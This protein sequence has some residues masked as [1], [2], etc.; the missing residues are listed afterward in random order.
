MHASKNT[1]TC[2]SV[3]P[4]NASFHLLSLDTPW[5]TMCFNQNQL[6]QSRLGAEKLLTLLSA[7]RHFWGPNGGKDR[8]SWWA[9]SFTMDSSTLRGLDGVNW[10][11]NICASN[12][13]S[14]T[15]CPYWSVRPLSVAKHRSLVHLT[16][17]QI[18]EECVFA[19]IPSKNRRFAR[20]TAPQSLLVATFTSFWS[21]VMVLSS[22]I[23]LA[24]WSSYDMMLLAWWCLR[25]SRFRC[26]C[27]LFA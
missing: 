11:L 20:R 12:R 21:C 19:I 27:N 3:S 22:S 9:I 17:S 2:V 6:M 15:V 23:C 10:L 8:S 24:S 4:E 7:S 14:V 16:W 13:R 5:T 25:C 1:R 26:S 18:R